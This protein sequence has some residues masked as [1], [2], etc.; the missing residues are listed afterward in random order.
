MRFGLRDLIFLVVLLGVPLASFWFVFKP[1]NAE[2]GQAKKEIEHKEQM[3][4]SLAAAT[5]QTAD[6]VKA[7]E[8]IGK[9]IELIEARLPTTKEVEVILQQVAEIA[10]SNKLTLVKVKS[11]K[12]VQAAAYM[13]Q[14]LTMEVSGP[15]EGFYSFLLDLERLDRITRMPDLKVKRADKEDGKIEATF[16]L[17]IYFE[18]AKEPGAKS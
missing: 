8:E 5:S 6:L 12:P 17:S 13:E 11:E 2:I 1:Q 14:P 7:N 16:T 9:A 10:V 4:Q 18:S 3:L 15:F